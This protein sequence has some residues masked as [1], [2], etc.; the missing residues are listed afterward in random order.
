MGWGWVVGWAEPR[1]NFVSLDYGKDQQ[2]F[3]FHVFHSPV[4]DHL[5]LQVR[6]ADVQVCA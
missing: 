3:T 5:V 6:A 2:L 1:P 4:D